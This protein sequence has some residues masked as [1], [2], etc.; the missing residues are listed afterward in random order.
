MIHHDTITA[1]RAPNDGDSDSGSFS[2]IEDRG[3][4]SVYEGGHCH[5]S[6]CG[7]LEVVTK[8]AQEA[9]DQFDSSALEDLKCQWLN[10]PSFDIEEAEGF[11]DC[12]LELYSFRLATELAAA[13]KE[14]QRLH[15]IIR[16]FGALLNDLCGFNR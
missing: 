12:R 9:A 10:D 15:S 3:K 4:F 8:I 16:P 6:D 11:E 2:I 13:R 14:I 7:S 5:A 1:K